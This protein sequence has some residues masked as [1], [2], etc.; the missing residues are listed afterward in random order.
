MGVSLEHFFVDD[1]MILVEECI[2][3]VSLSREQLNGFSG[4]VTSWRTQLCI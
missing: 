4:S 1:C 2:Y 3:L